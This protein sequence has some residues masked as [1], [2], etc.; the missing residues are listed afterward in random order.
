VPAREPGS[1]LEAAAAVALQV[2]SSPGGLHAPLR[3]AL[4]RTDV[5]AY[6]VMCSKSPS[7]E[8]IFSVATAGS[9]P[10]GGAPSAGPPLPFAFFHLRIH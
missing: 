2:R 3:R 5:R 1:G 8:T 4:K 6:A 7:I 9:L 10:L